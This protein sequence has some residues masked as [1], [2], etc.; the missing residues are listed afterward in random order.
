LVTIRRAREEDADAVGR[1]HR[2]SIRELC[3]GHYT[4]EQ[5]AAWSP[6]RPPGHYEKAIREK[7]FYVAEEGGR[8]VGF[9]ALNVGSG[10]VE[11]VYVGPEAV[12]RGVGMKLLRKVEERARA[13]GLKGLRV[14]ASLNAVGFYERAGY[15]LEDMGAHR[16]WNSVD[17]PCAHMSKE[18]AD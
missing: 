7:E 3:R 4:A 14:D 11:A 1:V 9:G 18:L 17:L 16:L 13:A 5:I 6:P 12:G 2:S 15:S 10:E 8:V